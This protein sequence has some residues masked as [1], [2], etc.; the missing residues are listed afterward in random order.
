ML[1]WRR[2]A[3]ATAA[4]PKKIALERADEAPKLRD[5]VANSDT[6]SDDDVLNKGGA[7]AA[8]NQ[9]PGNGG[10]DR[11]AAAAPQSASPQSPPPQAHCYDTTSAGNGNSGHE[12]GTNLSAAE[13]DDLVAYLLTF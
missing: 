10:Y 8:V 12:Y 1:R 9:A 13:K 3:G 11:A 7:G 6:L 4:A 5:E 2:A